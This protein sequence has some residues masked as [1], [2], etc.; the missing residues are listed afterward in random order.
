MELNVPQPEVP[1]SSL[2]ANDIQLIRGF[3]LSR[4]VQDCSPQTLRDYR[5]RLGMFHRYVVG[6]FP[7]VSL[8][9]IQRRHIEAYIVDLRDRGRAPW[10]LRTNYRVLRAFYAWAIE[11]Q[12]IADSPLQHIKPPRVPK[13]GKDFLTEAE[14][15]RLLRVCPLRRFTGARNAAI[16]WLLWTTGMRLG[17]L[18]GLAVEDLYWDKGWIKVLGKG[19]KERYVPFLPDAKRAIWRYQVFRRD[20]LPNLWLTEERTPLHV[21]GI[22]SVL[23]RVYKRAG[24]EVKDKAHVFRR[25][26]AARNL[27]AG[28]S[29]KDI[30]LAG[31]WESVRALEGYVR[32]MRVE[33]ALG[34]KWS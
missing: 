13:L 32:A 12:F 31:G 26:W 7:G 10:T 11:E 22:N 34:G 29:V 14:R 16:V 6:H 1:Q 28:R 17:E 3:A 9:H 25:S 23:D 5:S 18:A 24:V 30:Q 33:D 27:R 15:D 21:E 19:R 4:E 8:L 20:A 2:D